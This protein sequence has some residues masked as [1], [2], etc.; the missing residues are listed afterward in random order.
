MT[1]R[2]KFNLRARQ[3]KLLKKTARPREK[4]APTPKQEPVLIP[5]GWISLREFARKKNLSEA[6]LYA[7]IKRGVLK[8]MKIGQNRC[9][10]E[11]DYTAYLEEG[12]VRMKEAA[13]RAY[14]AKSEKARRR[15]EE[16]A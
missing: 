5:D 7:A 12:K 11:C 2:E 16:T 1:A 14:T 13:V 4:K 6:G 15:R 10:R 3:Q 8:S 9:L